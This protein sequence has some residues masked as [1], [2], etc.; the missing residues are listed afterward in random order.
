MQKHD[1]GLWKPTKFPQTVAQ[2]VECEE[3]KKQEREEDARLVEKHRLEK[4]EKAA[5]KAKE[6]K[7]IMQSIEAEP[8]GHTET[9]H[10]NDIFND[11]EYQAF[12]KRCTERLT[13]PNGSDRILFIWMCL[14]YNED[15]W[16]NY[17]V[18]SVDEIKLILCKLTSHFINVPGST[19]P[20]LG[21]KVKVNVVYE[22]TVVSDDEA[23]PPAKKPRVDTTEK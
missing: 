6:E 23:E 1:H 20:V 22:F 15:T 12:I 21:V 17:C 2:R 8:T 5:A 7:Q 19:I 9:L 16:T 18:Q 3:K 11:A 13:Q 10:I 14:V 4:A